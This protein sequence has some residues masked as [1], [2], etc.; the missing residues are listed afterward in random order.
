LRGLIVLGEDKEK[1]HMDTIENIIKELER[2]KLDIAR[3][4]KMIKEGN[5]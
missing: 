2:L 4:E 3:L 5:R 1:R